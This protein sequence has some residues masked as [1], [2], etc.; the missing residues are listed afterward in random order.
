M[1][2]GVSI[3]NIPMLSLADEIEKLNK[4]AIDYFHLDVMDGHFVENMT[5]GP[6]IMKEIAKVADKPLDIHLMVDNPKFFIE[7]VLDIHPKYVTVHYEAFKT[8]KA[9]F[10]VLEKLRSAGI[11]PGLAV[12]PTTP[13]EKIKPFLSEVDVLL[14]MTVQPG[15]GGQ[16]FIEDTLD[17]INQ[18]ASWRQQYQ[19]DYVIEVDGGINDET[20]KLCVENGVDILVL[21]SYL[22][23]APNREQALEKVRGVQRKAGN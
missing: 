10:D 2:I 3:L 6:D 16:S 12:N 23:C 22:V 11:L 17:N 21:G 5:F 1:E 14:Q 18:F 4:E 9:V 19:Y 13:A 7:K 15:F 20:G 8:D